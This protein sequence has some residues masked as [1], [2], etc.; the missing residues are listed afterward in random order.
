MKHLA[1]VALLI[2]APGCKS[3]LHV[4][5]LSQ[6]EKPAS[7]IEAARIAVMRASMTV[8]GAHQEAVVDYKR[9]ILTLQELNTIIGV[10]TQAEVY[11]DDA[12]QALALASPDVSTAE[13]SLVLVNAILHRVAEILARKKG[14]PA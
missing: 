13:K 7:T 14:T 11:V 5:G 4:L 3:T 8:S 10:L 1:L 6:H 12:S 2:L 9:G